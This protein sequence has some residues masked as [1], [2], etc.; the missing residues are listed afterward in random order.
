MGEAEITV[1]SGDDGVA[2]VVEDTAQDTSDRGIILDDCH[3]R[4]CVHPL[5]RVLQP[6]SLRCATTT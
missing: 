6:I 5:G 1:R 2:R 4:T 3:A